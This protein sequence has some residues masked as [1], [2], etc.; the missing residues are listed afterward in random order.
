MRQRDA[1]GELYLQNGAHQN[2]QLEAHQ[3][4]EALSIQIR[5]DGKMKDQAKAMKQ[6]AIKWSDALRTK[7]IKPH[8]AWYCLNAT[9]M[10]TLESVSYTHLTLPTKA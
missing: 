8:E 4:Q 2:R 5:P 1:P 10:K 7:K 9:I 3:A 6:K